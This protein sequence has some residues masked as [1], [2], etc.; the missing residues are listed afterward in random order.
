MNILTQ[1]GRRWTLFEDMKLKKLYASTSLYE[2]EAEFGRSISAIKTRAH[3]LE[4]YQG[5]FLDCPELIPQD[6]G[7]L[8]VP[9]VGE[10]GTGLCAVIDE[11]DADLIGGYRWHLADSGYAS[12]SRGG[13]LLHIHSLILD[14]PTGY[15]PDHINRDRLDN[16]RENLR[17]ATHRQNQLNRGPRTSSLSGYKGVSLVR[18]NGKW[19]ARIFVDGCNYSLGAYESPE[20]AAR[21]YDVAAK[22]HFGEFAYLNFP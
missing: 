15:L 16:R 12:V 8:L 21:A 6:D 19:Q 18:S 5:R 2:L 1:S 13:K 20:D 17:K 4:L 10:A 22:H 7:T 14:L 3:R 11:Q 9:M